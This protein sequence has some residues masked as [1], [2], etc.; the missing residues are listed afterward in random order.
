MPSPMAHMLANQMKQQVVLALQSVVGLTDSTKDDALEWF[1]CRM[2]FAQLAQQ[3]YV[4]AK[5]LDPALRREVLE[6]WA[7]GELV[8]PETAPVPLA[9][10]S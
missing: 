3:A 6:M 7:R 5:R 4:T 2:A 8:L 9:S 1:L 10:P